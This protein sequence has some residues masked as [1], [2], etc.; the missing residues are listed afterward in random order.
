MNIAVANV[1]IVRDE[2]GTTM[3]SRVSLE[4]RLNFRRLD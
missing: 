3:P 2:P 1:A 4:M